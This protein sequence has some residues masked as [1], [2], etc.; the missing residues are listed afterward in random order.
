MTHSLSKD[1]QYLIALSETHP[2]YFGLLGPAKRREQLIN[3]LLE[4][5]PNTDLAFIEKLRGPAGINIGA[6]NS[7]EIAVSVLA[8][9]LSVIRNQEPIPLSV[10]KGRIHE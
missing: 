2:I 10:K 8:E 3:H 4:H 9:I 1:V 5:K 6:E 7:K